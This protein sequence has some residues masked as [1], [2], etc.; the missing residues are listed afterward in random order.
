VQDHLA[1]MMELL[2]DMSAKVCP[3]SWPVLLLLA[4]FTSFYYALRSLFVSVGTV[5]H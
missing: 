3:S 1:F 4:C 2:G 5:R